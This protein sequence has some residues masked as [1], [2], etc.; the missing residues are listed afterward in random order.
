M[1][2]PGLLLASPLSWPSRHPALVCGVLCSTSG[3]GRDEG[4]DTKD[5]ATIASW[6]GSS[7]WLENLCICSSTERADLD[8]RRQSPCS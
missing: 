6:E 3:L 1:L 8:L 7:V 5:K 2:H 4:G